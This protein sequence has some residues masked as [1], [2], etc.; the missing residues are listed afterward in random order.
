MASLREEDGF[1]EEFPL[2]VSEMDDS[3]GP[4]DVE[5]PF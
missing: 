1:E 5:I 4:G 3:D 2:D